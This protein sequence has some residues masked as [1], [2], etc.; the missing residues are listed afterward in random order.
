EGRRWSLRQGAGGFAYMDPRY[1][2]LVRCITVVR[3][4]GAGRSQ[5]TGCRWRNLPPTHWGIRAMGESCMGKR[6]W[7][8][9]LAAVVTATVVVGAP[10]PASADGFE[11]Q[12]PF[13]CLT[14]QAGLGQPK[15]DNHER[16]GT[17]VYPLAADGTPDRNQDPIGWSERCQVDERIEYRYRTTG[18][19]LR[20]LPADATELPADI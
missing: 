17:P 13:L 5:R 1:I 14:E 18:G 2:N 3:W 16:R 12:S 20:T 7:R 19:E 9:A 6:V 4:I 10:G 15:V 8:A 11:A